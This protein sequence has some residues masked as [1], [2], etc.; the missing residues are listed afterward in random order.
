MG[1]TADCQLHVLGDVHLDH[2]GLV[3]HNVPDRNNDLVDVFLVDQF[4]VLETL[5]HVVDKLLCHL[6]LFQAH[7]VVG[8]I[9][10]HRVDIETLGGGQLIADF[11]S[12]EEGEL[13]HNLLALD[14]LELGI[15]VIGGN[16]DA[17]LEVLDGFLGVQDGGVGGSAAVVGLDMMEGFRLATALVCDLSEEGN[18]KAATVSATV[19]T[20]LDEARVELNGFCGI[21]NGISV[22]FCLEM[23]LCDGCKKSLLVVTRPIQE[24]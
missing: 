20:Y 21:A 14:K 9:D 8:G 12:G 24:A 2:G 3:V 6:V 7:A 23:G 13:A 16:L 18:G 4:A 19:R 11:D 22:C 5:D 10:S 17:G 15:L 1:I